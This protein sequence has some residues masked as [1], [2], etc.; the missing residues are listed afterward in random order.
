MQ[1]GHPPAAL[2][3][4]QKY[5]GLLTNVSKMDNEPGHQRKVFVLKVKTESSLIPDKLGSRAT[6]LPCP[7]HCW[8]M[9]LRVPPERQ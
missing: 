9:V 3:A 6:P 2:T 1:Q 4:T 5:K 7:S 8:A